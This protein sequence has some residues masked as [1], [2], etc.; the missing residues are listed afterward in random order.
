MSIHPGLVASGS[1]DCTTRYCESRKC[2]NAGRSYFMYH[3]PCQ[4][5]LSADLLTGV[6]LCCYRPNPPSLPTLNWPPRNH[7]LPFLRRTSVLLLISLHP[8]TSTPELPASASLHILLLTD[9][10]TQRCQKGVW[11]NRSSV[12]CWC[13]PQ[14][15]QRCLLFAVRSLQTCQPVRKNTATGEHFNTAL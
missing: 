9:L 15:A 3:S 6:I 2:I 4:C 13:A 11:L 10:S 12:Y 1:L 5:G 8:P 14:S 7:H